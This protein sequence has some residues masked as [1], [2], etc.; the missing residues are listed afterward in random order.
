MI[1][2]AVP[3]WTETTLWNQ[4][5]TLTQSLDALASGTN[6]ANPEAVNAGVLTDLFTGQLGGSRQ[7]LA[8][9]SEGASLLNT[10]NGGVQAEIQ[11][12]SQLEHVMVQ[13]QNST[14]SG[15]D[16]SQLQNQVQGLVQQ[17][18]SVAQSTQYNGIS[19]LNGTFAETTKT[20]PGAPAGTTT[21]YTYSTTA[22]TTS[23]S[24]PI[25]WYSAAYDFNLFAGTSGSN[26]TLGVQA[27]PSTVPSG[28]VLAPGFYYQLPSGTASGAAIVKL[29][30]D[31]YG[32]YV[33]SHT[34]G[35]YFSLN[36]LTSTGWHNGWTG[37]VGS[38]VNATVTGALSISVP[39]GATAI[40]FIEVITTTQTTSDSGWFVDAINP[41]IVVATPTT[42]TVPGTPG[43]TVTTG[44]LILQTGP[45]NQSVNQEALSL[46]SVTAAALGLG[47]LSV[48]SSSDAATGL[49]AVQTALS[50]LTT[51][52]STIGAQLQGLQQRGAA[53]HAENTNLTASL[54]TVR[55]VSIPQATQKLATSKMLWKTGLQVLNDQVGWSRNVE[56][57]LAPQVVA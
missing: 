33:G 30:L 27:V 7:A 48:S 50:Q 52:Q 11:I 20:L 37:S 34:S 25:V 8:N 44:G 47:S 15:A 51:Y 13:A 43:G 32:S 45:S 56:H 39:S 53:L 5:Q 19:L 42:T 38:G 17:L 28:T 9:V 41:K 46:P 21:T 26:P 22:L 12:V 31:G 14:L 49:T 40:N 10:A 55:S 29:N 57:L 24:Y 54:K 16:R 18:D 36:Y 3:G 6:A 2:N 35:D 23:N 4:Q 1:A